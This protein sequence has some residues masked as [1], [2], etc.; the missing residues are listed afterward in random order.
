MAAAVARG[1]VDD[2]HDVEAGDDASVLGG[3]AL[4]VVEVGRDGDDGVLDGG[5]E[6]G[7]GDL[8]HL[9]EHHGGDLLGRELLLLALVGHHD[10]WL[11]GRARDD[12]ERPHLHVRLHGRIREAPGDE[13]LGICMAETERLGNAV[14]GS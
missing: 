10:H 6:V 13:S 5:A 12:L 8:L 3:L 1:L 2:A 11:V 9:G 7:L 14:D 4:R